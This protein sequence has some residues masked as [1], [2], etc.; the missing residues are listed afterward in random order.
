MRR[1]LPWGFSGRAKAFRQGRAAGLARGLEA[2]LSISRDEESRSL[3]PPPWEALFGLTPPQAIFAPEFE[4]DFR[5]GWRCGL[6]E[7]WRLHDAPALADKSADSL[8]AF[9]FLPG[10]FK[11]GLF[12][13]VGAGLLILLALFL[14]LATP[15]HIDVLRALP[16]DTAPSY[17]HAQE[18]E[19]APETASKSPAPAPVVTAMRS[20]VVDVQRLGEAPGSDFD[21]FVNAFDALEPNPYNPDLLVGAAAAAINETRCDRSGDPGDEVIACWMGEDSEALRL[22]WPIRLATEP[23][24][25]LIAYRDFDD[26]RRSAFAAGGIA[27][28]RRDEKRSQSRDE[29]NYVAAA[30][31]CGGEPGPE[32]GID[33]TVRHMQL[34]FVISSTQDV[35]R[36]GALLRTIGFDWI[37]QPG[38]QA[39]PYRIELF[40]LASLY[41]MLETFRSNDAQPIVLGRREILPRERLDQWRSALSRER[42]LHVSNISDSQFGLS[43]GACAAASGLTDAYEIAPSAYTPVLTRSGRSIRV[44]APNSDSDRDRGVSIPCSLF[45]NWRVQALPRDELEM[46]FARDRGFHDGYVTG[47]LEFT[48]PQ[49]EIPDLLR[50]RALAVRATATTLHLMG[51]ETRL[52]PG[53]TISQTRVSGRWPRAAVRARPD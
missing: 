21:V 35:E 6:R 1:F 15:A 17:S 10:I 18:A 30:R 7:A 44:P 47:Q 28:N 16:W 12:A 5:D 25:A 33:C 38:A 36:Y 42:P 23:S 46:M 50:E 19:A 3:D 26:L 27:V 29:E 11:G 48:G 34:S 14:D 32:G 20:G 8:G 45:V 41:R 4:Q 24:G 2:R 53:E 43:R 13:F 52:L 39:E 49:T 37:R 40:A 22:E 31:V 51:F 9:A